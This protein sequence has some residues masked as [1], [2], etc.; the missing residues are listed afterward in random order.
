MLL[1]V[2]SNCDKIN[3]IMCLGF[4]I[5]MNQPI[6]TPTEKAKWLSKTLFVLVWVE[7]MLSILY[8]TSVVLVVLGV[9]ELMLA[10]LLYLASK[11]YV[12]GHIMVYLFIQM[13]NFSLTLCY[14]GGL[15]QHRVM[16]KELKTYILGM[17]YHFAVFSEVVCIIAFCFYTVSIIFGFMAYREF[18]AMYM[19]QH[20][21]INFT[22]D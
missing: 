8:F 18:K 21:Q 4:C 12:Q 17:T 20:M 11:S 3:S 6:V 15:I 10:I 13:F 16:F 7:I 5:G 2:K 22:D 9:V 14:L 19:E 1:Y